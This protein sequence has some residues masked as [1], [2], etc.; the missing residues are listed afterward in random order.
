M[1]VWQDLQPISWQWGADGGRNNLCGRRTHTVGTNTQYGR[2]YERT[3]LNTVEHNVK[4]ET[5]TYNLT[6][7]RIADVH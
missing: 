6:K 5:C 3:Q 7:M 1:R 2:E 4:E